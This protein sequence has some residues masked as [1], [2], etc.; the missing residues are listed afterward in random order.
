MKK[1]GTLDVVHNKNDNFAIFACA[2]PN[3]G[4]TQL[5]R[6]ILAAE[7][8]TAQ[9]II[10]HYT[11]HVW[12][13]QHRLRAHLRLICEDL[14][15]ITGQDVAEEEGKKDPRAV[16]VVHL[17]QEGKSFTLLDTSPISDHSLRIELQTNHQTDLHALS[18]NYNVVGVQPRVNTTAEMWETI[19]ELQKHRGFSSEAGQELSSQLDGWKAPS[20]LKAILRDPYAS[21]VMDLVAV[22]P[23]LKDASKQFF[24]ALTDGGA[25]LTPVSTLFLDSLR[26]LITFLSSSERHSLNGCF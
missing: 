7:S 12:Q 11:I 17:F 18:F 22:H 2:V 8:D 20:A 10:E 1:W 9:F 13:G 16:W 26:V 23:V 15:A 21:G 25:F 3:D 5:T 19:R 14:K 24:A 6:N 4:T